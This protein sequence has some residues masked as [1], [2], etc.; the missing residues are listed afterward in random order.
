MIKSVNIDIA[1]DVTCTS[2]MASI[3]PRDIKFTLSSKT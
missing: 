2:M 3:I 1:K